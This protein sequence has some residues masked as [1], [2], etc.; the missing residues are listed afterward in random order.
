[1][2]GR[3]L[4]FRRKNDKYLHGLQIWIALPTHLEQSNPSFSHIDKED[5]PTCEQNKDSTKS[6]QAKYKVKNRR[7]V[8]SPL[9]F[10]EIKT[11]TAKK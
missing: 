10:S 3:L 9:Y 7:P 2:V 1:M 11:K 5:I 6:L 4:Q 8:H